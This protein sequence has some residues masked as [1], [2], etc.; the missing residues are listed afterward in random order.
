MARFTDIKQFDGAELGSIEWS[1]AF[2]VALINLTLPHWSKGAFTFEAE[3]PDEAGNWTITWSSDTKVAA[4]ITLI[5]ATRK[6]NIVFSN[7]TFETIWGEDFVAQLPE[8]WKVGTYC[9]TT[10]GLRAAAFDPTYVVPPV[11]HPDDDDVDPPTVRTPVQLV[12]LPPLEPPTR[13][14]VI[15]G[16]TDLQVLAFLALIIGAFGASI[17]VS[18]IMLT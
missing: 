8:G 3:G 9:A 13:P 15:H 4:T 18:M 6:F 12:A 7:M 1:A 14:L 17:L 5:A 16:A 2:M 10:P 11:P